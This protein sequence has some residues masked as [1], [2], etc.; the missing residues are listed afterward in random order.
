M[1]VYVSR[2]DCSGRLRPTGAVPGWPLAKTA[3]QCMARS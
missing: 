2:E 1:K 3:S